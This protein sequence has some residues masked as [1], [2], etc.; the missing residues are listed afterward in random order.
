MLPPQHPRVGG[1]DTQL[2]GQASAPFL[3]LFPEHTHLAK[4]EANQ[5]ETVTMSPPC[6]HCLGP[7]EVLQPKV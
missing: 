7:W 5:P 6:C 3:C 4:M 1:P 2:S